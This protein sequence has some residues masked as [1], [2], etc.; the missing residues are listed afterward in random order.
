MRTLPQSP[1]LYDYLLSCGM[2]PDDLLRELSAETAALGGPSRMQIPADQGALLQLLSS[3]VAPQLAVEIG[4]FTGYSAIWIARGLPKGAKLVCC[5]IS[6]EWTSIAQRYWE[7]AN[8][9]DRIHLKLAPATETLAS[10]QEEVGFAFI[11]ADKT[12]YVDYYEALVP[13]LSTNGVIVVDN[14]LWSG[15]VI[16]QQDSTPDTQA[17]RDFNSHVAQD[18][19]TMQVVLPIGDGVTLITHAP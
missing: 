14:V 7:R 19:R 16:D 4:T 18:P 15:Q 12:S 11:D 3:L 9:S 2:P 17:L 8:L 10:I 5:D 1:E 6:Q 13:L